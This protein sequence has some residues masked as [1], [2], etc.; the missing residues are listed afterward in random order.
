MRRRFARHLLLPEIGADGQARLGASRVR[1]APGADPR[2]TALA[3]AYLARAGLAIADD[4]AAF[5]CA[6]AATVSRLAGAPRHEAAA[7]ALAGA[8][9]AV[10][11]IKRT[12]A[13]G[14]PGELPETLG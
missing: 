14:E 5:E 10:E 2:A 12:L 3:Y 13:L 7:A 11:A 8:F 9:A 6:D 4:G 1:A